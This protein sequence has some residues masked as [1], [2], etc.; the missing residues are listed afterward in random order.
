MV[1]LRLLVADRLHMAR[2]WANALHGEPTSLTQHHCR[3]LRR[4]AGSRCL[5]HRHRSLR[6]HQLECP[7]MLAPLPMHF[8]HVPPPTLVVVVK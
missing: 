6:H 7:T 5:G 2:P 8:W 3:Y 1:R 4:G